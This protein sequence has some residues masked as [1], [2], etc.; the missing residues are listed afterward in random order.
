MKDASSA[1]IYGAR[2]A[3]GVVLI[4]TKSGKGKPSLSFNA[5]TSVSTIANRYDLA[6]P[7]EFM[8][9]IKKTLDEAGFDFSGVGSNDKG[10]NTDWQDQVFQT[11]ISNSYNLAWGFSNSKSSLK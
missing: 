4:T 2:G 1:A 7:Q 8:Y 9:G 10:Y 11:A 3:N 5:T 6:S